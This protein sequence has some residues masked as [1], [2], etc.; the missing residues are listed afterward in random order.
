VVES[1]EKLRE[2]CQAPVIE[3]GRRWYINNV[4]RKVS[5]YITS[6]LI[7]THI[8]ANQVTLLGGLV[9]AVAGLCFVFGY[10]WHSVVGALLLQLW[11]VVD[12]VD[13][14]V[15]RY[16]RSSSITGVYLD[17]ILDGFVKSYIFVCIAFGVYRQFHDVMVFLFAFSAALSR[18]FLELTRNYCPYKFMVQECLM[19]TKEGK[20]AK[21]KSKDTIAF[22]KRLANF[23]SYWANVL[24]CKYSAIMMVILVA[25]VTDRFIPDLTIG[26]HRLNSMYLVLILYGTLMPYFWIRR[27]I[28]TV[29]SRELEADRQALLGLK[30]GESDFK[31]GN[32]ADHHRRHRI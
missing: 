1:I 2:I 8:T 17:W 11:L 26:F 21:A 9:G 7:P 18:M 3:E 32:M 28:Y 27:T 23:I 19:V 12:C 5:I 31:K 10:Y 24:I 14:E 29:F 15:A 16:R 22:S 20:E 13:G 30:E 25:A 6:L 4:V